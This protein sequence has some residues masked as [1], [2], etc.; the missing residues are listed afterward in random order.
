[1]FEFLNRFLFVLL[2]SKLSTVKGL[3][4]VLDG[5]KRNLDFDLGTGTLVLKT[6]YLRCFVYFKDR[7]KVSFSCFFDLA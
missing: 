2:L 1:M 4:M 6:E 7:T 3:F 5:K